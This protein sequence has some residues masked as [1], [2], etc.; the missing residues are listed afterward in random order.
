[1]GDQWLEN[2]RWQLGWKVLNRGIM[3]LSQTADIL[4]LWITGTVTLFLNLTLP[5]ARHQPFALKTTRRHC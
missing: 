3:G 2:S 1:M 4:F 5:G